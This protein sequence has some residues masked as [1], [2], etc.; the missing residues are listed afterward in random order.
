MDNELKKPVSSAQRRATAAYLQKFD[1]LR[2]R[3]PKGQKEL[4]A[5][6]A[7]GNGESVNAYIVRLVMADMK[8][9]AAHE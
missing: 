2:I 5:Q 4:I 8:G 6:K 1:D 9:A 7:A 3:V